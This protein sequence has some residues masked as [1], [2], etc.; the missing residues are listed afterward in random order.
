MPVKRVGPDGQRR[1][2]F[3][4]VKGEGAKPTASLREAF[5]DRVAPGLRAAFASDERLDASLEALVETARAAWPSL[6]LE[7]AAFV[8]FVAERV[9]GRAGAV[10]SGARAGGAAEIDALVAADLYLAAACLRGETAAL[11]AFDAK[12]LSAVDPALRRAGTEASELDEVRQALRAMLLVSDGAKAP[13]LGQ[14][15]GRGGLVAWLRV[16]ALRLSL[17]K[18]RSARPKGDG[19]DD[20][21][22]RLMRIGDDVEHDLARA[23]DR[24]LFSRAFRQA[25]GALTPRERVLLAQ[26]YLDGVTLEGL[27]AL[28][29]TH[30]ATVARWLARARE[31]MFR[32]TRQALRAQEGLLTEEC[33]SILRAA[34]SRIE[35]TLRNLLADGAGAVDGAD[36][37]APDEGEGD[38]GEGAE[39]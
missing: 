31:R 32:G 10:E 8:T 16:C 4:R 19:G 28:H 25:V 20:E 5:L 6:S 9:E 36:L 14:Y 23:Q 7:P 33:D 3:D 34:Q 39:T 18:R 38:E 29:G 26:H 30:R 15:A 17:R 2:R 22:D 11:A 12:Y 1:G 37:A 21:L 13:S 24:A 27:A 35:I